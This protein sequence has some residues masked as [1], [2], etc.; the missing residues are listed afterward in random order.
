MAQTGIESML[1]EFKVQAGNERILTGR[2]CRT[3]RLSR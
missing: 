2:P 3:A 1:A